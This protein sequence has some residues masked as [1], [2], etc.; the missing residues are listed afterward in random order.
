MEVGNSRDFEVE[1]ITMYTGLEAEGLRLMVVSF[2]ND[3]GIV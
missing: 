1:L 2:G 3:A